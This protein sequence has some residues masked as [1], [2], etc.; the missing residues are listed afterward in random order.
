MTIVFS[1]NQLI[2]SIIEGKSSILIGCAKKMFGD[3]Y[4]SMTLE[5]N[6]SDNRGIDVM[7]DQIEVVAGTK[8][9][10]VWAFVILISCS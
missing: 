8:A 5:L 4:S 10:R 1:R 7:Q 3:Y 2:V 6:A 9:F